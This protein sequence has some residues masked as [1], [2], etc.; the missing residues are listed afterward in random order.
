MAQLEGQIR[1]TCLH[2][3]VALEISLAVTTLASGSKII[4]RQV[5][6]GSNSSLEETREGRVQLKHNRKEIQVWEHALKP[7]VLVRVI[8]ASFHKSSTLKSQRL[9]TTEVYL[10]LT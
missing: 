3:L 2:G 6:V 9:I 7:L 4:F 10:L 8:N 5:A 1:T